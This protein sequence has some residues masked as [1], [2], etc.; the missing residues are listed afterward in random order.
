MDGL[1]DE[2]LMGAF[3]LIEHQADLL[4]DVSCL[5]V[6]YVNGNEADLQDK[7]RRYTDLLIKYPTDIVCL[8]IGEGTHLAFNDPHVA[9]F[10]DREIAKVV[11]FHQDCRTQQVNGG[12]FKTIHEVPKLALT[13][14]TPGLFKSVYALLSYRANLKQMRSIIR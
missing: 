10:N 14:S 11:D 2:V 3:L 4:S 8:G 5:E 9:D 1:H 6:D 13:I 12:C 7:C